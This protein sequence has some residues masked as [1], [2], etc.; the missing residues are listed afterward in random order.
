[1]A[2]SPT[3]VPVIL[4]GGAGTRLWPASR[5][6]R[7]KQFLPLLGARSLFQDTV[8]RMGRLK[9][10]AEAVVVT[11]QAHLDAIRRQLEEIG[12]EAFVI[13]EPE[14][15]DSAPAMAAAA[16]WIAEHHPGA[17]AVC[18]ASDHHIPDVDAFCAAA[19][20]AVTAAL[21]GAIAT[22]GVRPSHA[23][24]AYGYLEPGEPLEIKGASRLRRFVEKPNG[25]TAQLYLDAGY[26]WNSG[27]FVFAAERLLEELERF[28][29]AVAEKA[30]AAHASGRTQDGVLSLGLDFLASPKI[31]IDYAVMEKTRHAAL[32]PVDYA[33]SDLGSW[34]AIHEAAARDEGG[35]SVMGQVRLRSSRDV[36]V[37]SST[38]QLVTV[39]GLEQVGVVVEPD[40]ILV[41]HLGSSQDVKALVDG[42]APAA[43][44]EDPELAR[45]G[46][47][48]RDWL[49][50][51]ALPIW[52]AMGADRQGGGFVEA[53]DLTGR[54]AERFRRVRV[55]ARM[56][57]VYA[58]CAALGW[59]GPWRQAIDHALACLEARYRRPDGLYRTLAA[60][61][62]QPLEEAALLYDQAFVLIALAAAARAMPERRRTLEAKA[63][64]LLDLI[65]AGFRHE[66]GGFVE[67]E[68]GRA[69]PRYGL[70]EEGAY[71][72]NAQ[73][74]LFE[75]ALG[76]RQVGEDARWAVVA[77]EIGDLCCSRF[78]DAK[79]GALTEL[80]E[81]D[82]RP[83]AGDAGRILDPGHHFEWA[84]LLEQWSWVSGRPEGA[85][86]AERLFAAGERGVDRGR[87]VVMDSLGA[88]FAARDRTARLWPQTERLKAA[89]LL[90]RRAGPGAMQTYLEAARE[91]AQTLASY[92]EVPLPGLW[93]DQM[94]PDGRFAEGP[95]PGSSLYHIVAAIAEVSG[96]RIT[97]APDP[98]KA[99]CAS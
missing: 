10:A 26:L 93:R 47:A 79:T 43:P 11:G 78:V 36:L 37:R 95:A 52:W 22:F 68:H 30:R 16:S 64:G 92:L 3:V 98:R 75:A 19:E 74:H 4:C 50:A 8:L 38:D 45:T 31:S 2:Q 34:Q 67:R 65:L 72:C 60:P 20:I 90:A 5:P 33:W 48:L 80:F 9:G 82:W 28:A 29:P 46:Q 53:L 63:S 35:N 56:A 21:E 18:V 85:R 24:T 88:D 55:Q 12:A 27:N 94:G 23:S 42:L 61:D 49:L 76:W 41:C 86:V 51:E 89:H 6:S 69:P 44:A 87:G 96:I 32:V 91:A 17:I 25:E 14:G 83:A 54:P 77:D 40:A 57:Y 70:A 71:Q 58:A 1:M 81:A 73:M 7:P 13:V 39:L 84:W 99:A 59:R 97:P 66:A 15:R 62:G